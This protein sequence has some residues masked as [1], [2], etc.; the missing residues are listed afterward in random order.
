[1]KKESKPELTLK[2]R[3]KTESL[4]EAMSSVKE[5]TSVHELERHLNANKLRFS[6]IGP[7]E[8]TAWD[9]H[10]VEAYDEGTTEF[11]LVGYSDCGPHQLRA[12]KFRLYPNAEQEQKLRQAMGCARFVYNWAL[13]LRKKDYEAQKANGVAKPKSLSIFDISRQLTQFK[14]KEEYEWLNDAPAISLIASLNNLDTAY[15]NFFRNVKKGGVPGFPKFKNRNGQQTIQ[16][17]QQYSVDFDKGILNA[18]KIP[19]IKTIFHRKFVGQSKTATISMTPAGN[20][21]VSIL[22]DELGYLPE[23]KPVERAVGIDHGIR[24]FL[25]LSDGKTWPRPEPDPKIVKRLFRESRKLSRK[26]KDSKNR[27]KQRKKLASVYEGV[28]NSRTGYHY[29]VANELVKY[30]QDKGYDTIFI[31][32]YDI[33]NMLKTISPKE[34]VLR[35]G[36]LV[37]ETNGRAQQR[38]LNRKISDVAWGGFILILTQFT[39][40]AGINLIKSEAAFTSQK[41]NHC[42]HTAVEN[43]KGT[44]FLCQACNTEK[45]VDLNAALNTRDDGYA[46][47]KVPALAG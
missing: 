10:A 9:L 28:S 23:L 32:D 21:Y 29:N 43:I 2:F 5:F 4:D 30:C 17:H 25:T 24:N 46:M 13:D 7:E 15:K 37:Y 11:Y 16:F 36:K 1:M 35:N 12:Y 44:T 19:G 40:K 27:N 3:P 33:K 18:P 39:A 41:C 14:K 22:V 38:K 42:G 31:R 8:E 26:E 47:V 34:K 20:F 45:D 6:Y